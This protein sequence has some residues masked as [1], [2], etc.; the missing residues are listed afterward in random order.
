EFC[1]QRRI[2]HRD[3]KPENI[4]YS[5]KQDVFKVGDFGIARKIE[6]ASTGTARRGTFV[7][8]APEVYQGMRYDQTADIYSLG[9]V[10]YRL[11]NNNR[12]PFLPPYPQQIRYTDREAALEKRMRGDP[13]P[14]PCNAAGLLGGIVLKACAFQP[15][16][17]YQRA[18]D[19]RGA[20]FRA[21]SGGIS[22]NSFYA[23]YTRAEAPRSGSDVPP[24][25]SGTSASAGQTGTQPDIQESIDKLA[26]VIPAF[27][28]AASGQ[29]QKSSG[30]RSSAGQNGTGG[31]KTPPAKKR[32]D[33]DGAGRKK[34]GGFIGAL[35][36]FILFF[37]IG[38]YGTGLLFGS[39]GSGSGSGGSDSV[40]TQDDPH[41]T[42]WKRKALQNRRKVTGRSRCGITPTSVPERTMTIRTRTSTGRCIMTRGMT[43]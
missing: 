38:R 26:D 30:V 21:G 19:L 28:G 8:M 41:R 33:P 23:E 22:G 14:M 27:V 31:R 10:L 35:I 42:D 18:V 36:A 11:L 16:A 24:T 13:I 39:A 34:A 43:G 29:G 5:P 37:L 4:F 6:S 40:V 7:Y 2:V 17:R 25:R 12:T 20:L 3:I 9:I 1:E 32:P 15:E